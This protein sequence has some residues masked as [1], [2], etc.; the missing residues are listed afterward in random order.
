MNT[1]QHSEEALHIIKRAVNNALEEDIGSGDVTAALFNVKQIHDAK[2]I[3]REEAVLCGQQW[4][5]ECFHQLDP[6]IE[7]NWNIHDG[8]V[9]EKDSTVCSLRGPVQA[10]LTGERTAIN[11]LQTLSATATLTRIYVDTITGTS[12]QLLDTRKTIPGMRYAQKYAVKCG[13]G[14][15]HRMGLFD[16]ILIK[17]NHIAAAG[18]I[19]KAVTL[20]KQKHPHLKLEVEVENIQQLEEAVNTPADTILLDNFSLSELEK[21]VNINEHKKK[22][23]ASGNISLENIREIAKTGIDF[24]SI[25]SITKHIQAVDFSMRFE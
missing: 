9:I 6:S 25:G 10:I 2:L 11:F 3:C 22:L 16:A 12:A 1:P 19:S 7:I 15:N 8:N 18:S 23:E 21:A 20:A 4:F 5:I 14:M 24:I 17:E 13:G